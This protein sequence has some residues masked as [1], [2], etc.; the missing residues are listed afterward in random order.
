[1]C[2]FP[3]CL[4]I[5]EGAFPLYVNAS[6]KKLTTRDSRVAFLIFWFSL[7]HTHIQHLMLNLTGSPNN[8]IKN[9]FLAITDS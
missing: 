7:I 4:V 1:M 5:S 8:F 2:I 6:C 9:K 3:Y